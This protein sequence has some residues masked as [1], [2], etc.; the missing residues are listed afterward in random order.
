MVKWGLFDTSPGWIAIMGHME[1]N[2]RSTVC[3]ENKQKWRVTPFFMR[4]LAQHL[5]ACIL[6]TQG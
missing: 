1:M 2:P 5:S 6:N 3:W 4:V